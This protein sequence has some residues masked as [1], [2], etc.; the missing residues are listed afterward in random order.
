MIMKKKDKIKITNLFFLI[1]IHQI[2]TSNKAFIFR[3]NSQKKSKLKYWA[4][5]V[6]QYDSYLYKLCSM[7]NYKEK[8]RIYCRCRK[9]VFTEL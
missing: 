4:K 2:F 9:I 8:S 5:T 1:K 7:Q 6:V 3:Q